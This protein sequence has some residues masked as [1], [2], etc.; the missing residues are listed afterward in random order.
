MN[1]S[2]GKASFL[3]PALSAQVINV[4]TQHHAAPSVARCDGFQVPVCG[5]SAKAQCS[6]PDS[7]LFARATSLVAVVKCLQVS[8]ALF[9][10]FCTHSHVSTSCSRAVI[11]VPVPPSACPGQCPSFALRVRFPGIA[12]RGSC[13]DSRSLACHLMFSSNTWC[14]LLCI[15]MSSRAR[16][17]YTIAAARSLLVWS[18]TVGSLPDCAG[19]THCTP[20]CAQLVKVSPAIAVLRCW[21][22]LF[23]RLLDEAVLCGIHLLRGITSPSVLSCV[24]LWCTTPSVHATV[25]LCPCFGQ[26]FLTLWWSVERRWTHR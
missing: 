9:Y 7:T 10:L 16:L 19:L 12:P 24:C 11:S 17:V 25:L 1:S 23:Q 8:V 13:S 21:V 26:R 2:E 6:L 20:S 18:A 5:S 22:L 15:P 14:R 3:L 4:A